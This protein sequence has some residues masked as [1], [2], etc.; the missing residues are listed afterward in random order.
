M[1]NYQHTTREDLRIKIQQKLGEE[2]VHWTVD[3]INSCI[4]EAL[5]SFGALSSFWKKIVFVETEENK[6]TYDLFI[7]A[8]IGLENIRP[9]I[10]YQ[11][12]FNWLNRDLM[13]NVNIGVDDSE[14]LDIDNYRVLVDDKYNLFQQLTNLILS[15]NEA[16]PVPANQ[17]EIELPEDLID[18]IRVAFV[19]ADGN[20]TILSQ[21]DEEEI[22][23]NS[24]SHDEVNSPLFYTNLYNETKTLKLFPTPANVGALRIVYVVGKKYELP[25][26]ISIINLPN[27]LV[28]YIK[29][30]VEADIFSNEGLF[31]DPVRAAYCKQRWEEGIL[32]GRNYTSAILAKANDKL[33]SL[34][35]LNNV[36]TYSDEIKVRTPPT[37]L[38]FGGFNIF[39][40]DVVPS[41]VNYT[42][43]ITVIANAEIPIDDEAFIKL[44]LEY[45]DTLADYVVHLLKFRN[46]ANEVAM[47][48]NLKDNFLK[49]AVNHN[50]RLLQAGITFDNLIGI[51]KKQELEQPR[52]PKEN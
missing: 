34:D 14:F 20:I 24:N 47:T 18:I 44:D 9:S 29:F 51:T 26:V 40:T 6:I 21:A 12:L 48:S 45:I 43:G 42:L 10:T 49:L 19:A 17:N 2:G 31:N 32:V 3:E 4:E 52:I 16:I 36:D 7:D 33:I 15:K 38:G 25:S 37:I 46:G 8:D 1:A 41:A 27:N 13:E 39:R 22:G 11:K 28:P 50:R 30:G 35:S 23:L 5:L